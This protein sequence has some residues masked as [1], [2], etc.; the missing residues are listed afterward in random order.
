MFLI[1]TDV[2]GAARTTSAAPASTLTFSR[3]ISP[4]SWDT[5]LIR[6]PLPTLL[7]DR[8]VLGDLSGESKK[9]ARRKSPFKSTNFERV[10]WG[11]LA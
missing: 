5:A 1:V 9:Y 8:P 10:C 11:A 2:P 6:T 3:R 7:P 4:S